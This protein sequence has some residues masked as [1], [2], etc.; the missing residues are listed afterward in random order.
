MLIKILKRLAQGGVYSN[1]LMAKELGVDESLVEQMITQLQKLGYIEK[2]DMGNCSSGCDCGSSKKGSCCGN[3]DIGIK[4]WNITEKG[5][6][7]ILV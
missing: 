4:M 5:K 3:Q 6:K 7:T 2:E 1:K